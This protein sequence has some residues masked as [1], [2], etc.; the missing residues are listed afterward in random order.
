MWIIVRWGIQETMSSI[1]TLSASDDQGAEVPHSD[2]RCS[3]CYHIFNLTLLR[4][5][6]LD[7]GL[8]GYVSIMYGT[9]AS[10]VPRS[11]HDRE[12]SIQPG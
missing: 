8:F 12:V 10:A 1:L 7:F 2:L 5:S 9:V 4:P 3:P 11:Y 6:Y